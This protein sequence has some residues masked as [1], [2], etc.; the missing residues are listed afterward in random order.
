MLDDSVIQYSLLEIN[1]MKVLI[2]AMSALILTACSQ[3]GSTSVVTSPESVATAY[4]ESILSHDSDAMKKVAR[5]GSQAESAWT[6]RS[7]S[8]ERIQAD[9]KAGT[10]AFK[11]RGCA[12]RS[13][14]TVCDFVVTTAQGESLSLAIHVK[15]DSA[16]ALKVEDA[17][18][19]R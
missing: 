17:L 16:G 3:G 14:K 7:S 9:P 5:S 13:D 18:A 1:H 6:S 2:A 11:N 12:D 10:V 4:M 19:G 15:K 8:V